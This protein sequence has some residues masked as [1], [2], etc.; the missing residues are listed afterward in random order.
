MNPRV[1]GTYRQGCKPGARVQ[2]QR[3]HD[4]IRTWI[5]MTL[6]QESPH[7]NS[8]APA[9]P[10]EGAARE[11]EPCP[12][13]P[14]LAPRRAPPGLRTGE[15]R[16]PTACRIAKEAPRKPQPNPTPD[17]GSGSRR[18]RGAGGRRRGPGLTWRRRPRTSSNPGSVATRTGGRSRKGENA[19]PAQEPARSPAPPRPRKH[20]DLLSSH[21]FLPALATPMA[22]P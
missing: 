14:N 20:T 2:T 12:S 1:G 19:A 17:P 5:S 21:W 8:D 22:R 6:E 16:Q 4:G 7:A 18:E 10:K 3:R 11:A 15:Q 9:R 13:P